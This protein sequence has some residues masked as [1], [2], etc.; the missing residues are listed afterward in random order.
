MASAATAAQHDPAVHAVQAETAERSSMDNRGVLGMLFGVSATL[1]ACG[2]GDGATG[3]GTDASNQVATDK[4]ALSSSPAQRTAVAP[5]RK[6]VAAE[7]V[8]FLLQAQFAATPADVASLTSLG[9]SGWLH[10]QFNAPRSEGGYDWIISSGNADPFKG[11]FFNPSSADFMIWR[12]LIA[13]PDQVR[14]RLALALSEMFVVSTN[15]M[16]AFWP[17]SFMGAYWDVLTKNTFG[18]FRGLLEDVTLNPAMGRYL[19]MLGSLKEDPGTGRLPDENF[20]REVMQLF[21]IGLSQLNPDGTP[22]LDSQGKPIDAYTQSD[23]SNLA[24]VFTGYDYDNTGVREVLTPFEAYKIPSTEYARNR[25]VLDASKHSNLAATF[26]GV[27]VPANTPGLAALKIALDTLF[28]H[29]NVGPYFAR[30]M[31]QRLVTSNPSPA[32]VQRVATAFNNNGTGVRGDMKA[33]WRA[34]LLDPEARRLP[35]ATTAG[36]VREPMVRAVQWARTFKATSVDGAWQVFDHSSSEFALT[37]SPLRAASVF[38]FFRP[39]YVPPRTAIARAGLVAPEFQGHNE[40]SIISYLNY[41]S[42]WVSEGFGYGAVKANYS[43]L[44]PLA[45]DAKG[46]VQWM[47]LHL[48][49]NQLSDRTLKAMVTSVASLPVTAGSP[50]QPRLDRI[51]AAIVLVMACPEYIVQK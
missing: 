21:T 41:L 12:Q 36:K 29:P 27:T 30:Q 9:V 15:V 14:M 10:Q 48:T 32:Y 13:S 47:N 39:G 51:Y 6:E 38:N 20:A 11:E 42:Y 45:A 49:A 17:G 34:L 50:V 46:L 18:N 28:K 2:G 26:L 33:F 35:S 4:A 25:M 3:V 43:D 40:S 19:N 37:Q 24:R 1:A 31:I 7:Q 44:L 22:K 16:D 5:V 8:R 23:V